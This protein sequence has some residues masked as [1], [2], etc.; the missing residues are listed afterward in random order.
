MHAYVHIKHTHKICN[1]YTRTNMYSMQCSPSIG[2]MVAVAGFGV[3]AFLL[4]PAA[5]V[6]ICCFFFRRMQVGIA[7]LLI[8]HTYMHTWMMHQ[9]THTRMQAACVNSLYT[10][11]QMQALPQEAYRSAN[12][13]FHILTTHRH[14]HALSHTRARIPTSRLTRN[15]TNK[16][17]RSV[18]S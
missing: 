3:L 9:H 11:Q 14:T 5:F 6:V 13:H 8:Q 10:R 17:G 16:G 2:L 15:S 18:V 4:C 12:P 1:A 7:S